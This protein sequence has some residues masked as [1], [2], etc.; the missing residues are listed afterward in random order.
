MVA[1]E[2]CDALASRQTELAARQTGPVDIWGRLFRGAAK[3]AT[4]D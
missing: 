1:V 3:E 4:Q 2:W